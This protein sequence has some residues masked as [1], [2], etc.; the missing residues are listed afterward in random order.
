MKL[1]ICIRVKNNN[2]LWLALQTIVKYTRHNL[3]LWISKLPWIYEI[4]WVRQYGYVVLFRI[5][6]CKHM[7]K[8]PKRSKVTRTP[9]VL[10]LFPIFRHRVLHIRITIWH[11]IVP[12]VYVQ[13]KLHV[14]AYAVSIGDRYVGW[15]PL[16]QELQRWIWHSVHLS[17]WNSHPAL[18][19]DDP[20]LLGQELLAIGHNC[21]GWRKPW[22]VN[23]SL[24][25]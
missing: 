6:D 2:L 8:L 11:L 25:V 21:N 12:S 16:A 14:F 23:C 18:V 4:H 17:L 5:L 13:G 15:L 1:F 7:M 20:M 3:T 9:E 24:H 19:H 10:I 22:G